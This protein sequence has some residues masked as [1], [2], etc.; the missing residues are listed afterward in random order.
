LNGAELVLASS[1]NL[2]RAARALAGREVPV[3]VVRWGLDFERFAPG[4]ASGAREALGLA[5]SGALVVNV[6]GFESV[7][8]P[9]LL[10]EAF[11]RVKTLRP[12]ARLLLK[13]ER[14]SE[15]IRVNAAVARLGLEDS[16]TIL[17]RR[18]AEMPDV[19]RAA[20]V[21]VSIS[22]SDSS[23][24]SVW[25]A[26]ACARP[27]VTSDLSWARDELTPGENALL[28]SL[29]AEEISDA[30]VH[31]LDDKSLACTL[32][33]KGR[34][35]ALRELDPAASAARIDAL[36]RSVLESASDPETL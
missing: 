17:G 10:L 36:Y 32:A 25:E 31:V 34:A 18:S 21:V 27:V 19:Y 16:V 2:A 8:N 28:V 23:P 7:Y 22:S 6:R 33:E 29:D 13:H 20:D 35:R 26:L 24:R 5:H 30:I 12:D 3:E 11:A 15:P 9:E 4:D 1:E 14:P